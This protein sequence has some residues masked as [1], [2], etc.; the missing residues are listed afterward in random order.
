[1]SSSSIHTA[2]AGEEGGAPEG[3]R[4]TTRWDKPFGAMTDEDVLSVL[5][6][7]P[8]KS[9]APDIEAAKKEAFVSFGVPISVY[10]IL[11]ND[12]RMRTFKRGEFVVR[13]GDYGNSA[14]FLLQG[15]L[16]RIVKPHLEDSALGRKEGLRR[17]YMASFIGRVKDLFAPSP[18]EYR[19]GGDEEKSQEV[20]GTAVSPELL[21]A[22]LDSKQYETDVVWPGEILGE[23]G[24]IYRTPRTN[25]IIADDDSLLIEIRWQGLRDIMEMETGLANH[26]QRLYREHRLQRD[27][28]T[29]RLFGVLNESQLRH[30][31]FKSYGKYDEWSADYLELGQEERSVVIET[32]EVIAQQGHYPNGIYIVQAGFARESQRVGHGHQTLNYLTAGHIFGLREILYNRSHRENPIPYEHSLRAIGYTHVLFVPTRLVEEVVLPKLSAAEQEKLLK[33]SVQHEGEK[34][35]ETVGQMMG[36]ERIGADLLEFFVENRFLIGTKTMLINM[37]RC[38]RC[39]DCVHACSAAHDGDP[40]F[41]RAGPI[42]GKF[43]VANACMHCLDPVCMIGCPT[44]AIHRES[45]AGLVVINEETCIGCATCYSNCPYDAIRMTAVRDKRGEFVIATAGDHVGSPI[46]KATKCDLC[47]DQPGGP[48]CE[49]ACPHDAL[50]RVSMQDIDTLASFVR[51]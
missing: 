46:Y 38:T 50:Q 15:R 6:C 26:I 25:T 44:G 24:A 42:H 49:R 18:P 4:R 40:R 39:D 35:E 1:M 19:P 12:T 31:Q 33:R 20:G 29:N 34:E 27:L 13:K 41:L 47:V 8:F 23:I 48:A 10:G 7:E 2:L 43:M 32:E 3:L 30:I 51:Q 9:M 37:D 16:Y 11:L 36:R 17:G 14:F 21:S 5:E 45:F 28:E 22:I